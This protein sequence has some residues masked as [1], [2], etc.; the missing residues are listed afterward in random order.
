M[1][2]R[3]CLALFIATIFL[4]LFPSCGREYGILEYQNGDVFAVCEVNGEYTV[5][6]IK[7][8][9]VRRLEIVSP[10]EMEGVS[11][12]FDEKCRIIYDGLELEMQRDDLPGVSALCSIFD[13]NEGM[14]SAVS[15]DE[16]NTVSF[17]SDTICYT[18]TYNSISLPERVVISGDFDYDIL[19]KSILLDK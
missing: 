8:E 18:V 1:K 6:I 16:Y 2:L 13:L 11:F 19:I 15:D 12:I 14:I 10:S 5:N 3:P 4:A 9:N 17:N 7:E